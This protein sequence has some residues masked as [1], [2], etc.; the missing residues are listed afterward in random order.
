MML[1][2]RACC[3]PTAIGLLLVSE[4]TIR[5]HQA[6]LDVFDRTSWTYFRRIGSALVWIIGHAESMDI[7]AVNVDLHLTPYAHSKYGNATTA[8]VSREESSQISILIP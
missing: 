5:Q 8:D 1:G 2:S 3:P 4:A 6:F 7:D